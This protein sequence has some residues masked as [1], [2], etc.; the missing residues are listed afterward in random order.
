M[1]KDF[2]PTLVLSNDSTY[3]IPTDRDNTR[4]LKKIPAKY[5]DYVDTAKALSPSD[6][7][8]I[9]ALSEADRKKLLPKDPVEAMLH[10]LKHVNVLLRPLQHVT[11]IEPWCMVHNLYKCFCKGKAI[12]GRPFTFEDLEEDLE[13]R[14]HYSKKRMYE[15]EKI[16]E[17]E[18]SK[19]KRTLSFNSADKAAKEE[20]VTHDKSPVITEDEDPLVFVST[21]TRIAHRCLSVDRKFFERDEEKMLLKKQTITQTEKNN[22]KLNEILNERILGC[23]RYFHRTARNMYN[24]NKEIETENKPPSDTKSDTTI[25]VPASQIRELN[26]PT[27]NI[28][29]NSI[30]TVAGRSQND[31]RPIRLNIKNSIDEIKAISLLKPLVEKN[32]ILITSGKNKMFAKKDLF[33]AG[34]LDFSK[35]I[36]RSIYSVS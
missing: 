8:D 16:E 22:P 13:E 3:L 15:F 35:V 27:K 20:I 36:K 28:V 9:I 2:T 1:E 14:Y 29:K 23:E 21:D 19:V 17:G 11:S 4:R 25:H 5:N 6:E 34:K 18:A 33:Y 24:K 12:E 30:P 32:V 31:K 26:V 10:Q 7:S